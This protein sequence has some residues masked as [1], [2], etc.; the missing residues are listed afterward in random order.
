MTINENNLKAGQLRILNRHRKACHGDEARA[1]AMF[2]I[3]MEAQP[4]KADAVDKNAIKLEEALAHL[5]NDKSFKLGNK[6]Y[7]VRK[8]K[9]K[10]ASGFVAK[11][12]E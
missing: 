6:G 9:G 1:Q 12:N 3:E 10:G 4:Q 7:T 5:V 2:K 11:R 8:A